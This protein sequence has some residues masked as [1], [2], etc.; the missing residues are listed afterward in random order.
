[1]EP[2]KSGEHEPVHY[3]DKD[4]TPGVNIPAEVC[5][6]CSDFEAGVLVPA[7]FCETARVKLDSAP[8]EG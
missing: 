8:W 3:Y 1:M 7:S 2:Q 4:S 6:T 5:G